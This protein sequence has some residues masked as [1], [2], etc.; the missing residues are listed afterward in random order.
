MKIRLNSDLGES[1]GS[2]KMGLDEEIFPYIDMANFAC[3]FHA[4][5]PLI[6]DE[7]IKLAVKH[8]ITIGAHPAYPDLVGFGRRSMVCTSLEIESMVIYQCGALQAFCQANGAKLSYVKPHGGLYN[9]MM[10]DERIFRAVLNALKRYDGSL[11]LMILSKVDT[12]HYEAIA[13]EFGINL[14]Y[15]V[16]A[17]R[18]YDDEG[19]LVPR[20]QKGSVLH[21]KELVKARLE[22]LKNEGLLETISGKKIALK[23]DS[24]CVHGDNE[25]A[26]ELVKMLRKSL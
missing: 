8:N 16:F 20:T 23:V 6:M 2:W 1:F 4:G 22:L 11:K 13:K 7:S 10:R 21:S 25:E 9:D 5:D 15:E 12:T 19:F 18:A 14:L 3:G 24:L 17:D 26:I